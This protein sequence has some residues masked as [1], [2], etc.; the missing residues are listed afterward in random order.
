MELPLKANQTLLALLDFRS[1]SQSIVFCITTERDGR[2]PR[3]EV[4]A[5]RTGMRPILMT[6]TNSLVKP[7][8]R[9]QLTI[10][11]K[12]LMPTES[13]SLSLKLLILVEQMQLSNPPLSWDFSPAKAKEAVVATSTSGDRSSKSKS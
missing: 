6:S 12:D 10:S 3:T 1:G 7:L 2:P 9:T 4:S 5:G 13:R 8:R 11:D